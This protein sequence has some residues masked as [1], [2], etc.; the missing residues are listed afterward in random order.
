MS[1]DTGQTDTTP[2]AIPNLFL[3]GSEVQVEQS[4]RVMARRFQKKSPRRPLIVAGHCRRL[5]MRLAASCDG[6]DAAATEVMLRA[7]L[8][9]PRRAAASLLDVL[10]RRPVE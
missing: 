6:A 2:F 10:L 8:I 3:L 1:S 5:L 4:L 9:P 7:A